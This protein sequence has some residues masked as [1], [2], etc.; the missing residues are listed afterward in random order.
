VDDPHG[1]ALSNGLGNAAWKEGDAFSHVADKNPE[2]CGACQEICK[3]VYVPPAM[4]LPSNACIGQPYQCN[5]NLFW[6]RE[7]KDP[8][9]DIDW[10]EMDVVYVC[11]TCD[12]V[13]GDV[14]ME[15]KDSPWDDPDDTCCVA[16]EMNRGGM[17]D[18]DQ[19]YLCS[20]KLKVWPWRPA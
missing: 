16:Y 5:R 14:I 10:S 8:V 6:T 13:W 15:H 4:S 12:S 17:D 20:Q 9:E 7:T 11:H 3:L 2:C 18:Y 1:P 19:G